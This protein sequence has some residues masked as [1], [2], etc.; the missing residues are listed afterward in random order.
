[1]SPEN[2]C[3]AGAGVSASK[4]KEGKTRRHRH[5]IKIKVAS[6]GSASVG[7]G[8]VLRNLRSSKCSGKH[9]KRSDSS[10]MDNRGG[11]RSSG[12][13]I[14]VNSS[15][16]KAD[17]S[18]PNLE[19]ALGSS[20][21][22]ST[23]VKSVDSLNVNEG[24]DGSFINK[25]LEVNPLDN[26]KVNDVTKSNGLKTSS[27]HISKNESVIASGVQNGGMDNFVKATT[28]NDMDMTGSDPNNEHTS[29]EDVVSTGMPHISD[30]NGIVSDKGGRSFEFG[31]NEKAKG[32]L[33]KPIGPLLTVHFDKNNF[34]NPFVKK[35]L[36]QKGSAWNTS[37][38]NGFGKPILSNQFTADADRFAEKLKQ[39]S[40]EM[41][42][43]MEYSPDAVSKLDNGTKRI[44][45]TAEEV[46]KGGLACA[47]QLYGYFVGTSMDYRV[48]SGNLMKMWRIHGIEE[49]TKT[50]N[51]IFYF[52][53]KSEE[54]MRTVLDSGPWMVQNVPLVLNI[55]EP[56]IW[57][58]KTEPTAIPIWVC[59]YNIPMELC[60]GNGIGK[61]MSGVGKPM[62]MD[63]MTKER[64]LKKAGK[65]DFAR[66]LVEV[67]ASED[68]PNVLEIE[69]PPMGN[70]PAKIGKLDVKYQWKPP[71]CT[72]CK[73]FGHTTLSC[74]I[75]PR[76]KDE[77]V[78]KAKAEEMKDVGVN[79]PK[80]SNIVDE[81]DNDGFVTVG[82]NN[83]PVNSKVKNGSGSQ[84]NNAQNDS[85]NG[86]GN[87]KAGVKQYASYSNGKGVL[88]YQGKGNNQKKFQ[89]KNKNYNE[90]N[91]NSSRGAGVHIKN[92]GPKSMKKEVF[93]KKNVGSTNEPKSLHKL[94]KDPN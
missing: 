70:R 55:W 81:V 24:N 14:D 13:N 48:V 91:M 29:M 92:Q 9:R 69:Y 63:R 46:S 45:F 51:G 8:S 94:S 56:G 22:S 1:M 2:I 87:Y 86:G 35:H 62:V 90:E 67:S 49:I 27:V 18:S 15:N 43:K 38:V 60:N 4:G 12:C 17:V 19:F 61:I 5:G 7:A 11:K 74:K 32:L 78:A 6:P 66:V 33:T 59:V 75:R 82:K 26:K 3:L 72:H 34:N 36:N 16:L 68:L 79:G 25:P 40:E 28:G 65:L 39:G 57:L 47:L 41:A 85:R 89:S 50:S 77:E 52:K 88:N 20:Y 10:P 30:L 21:A 84:F 23:A 64:C 31:K 83:K 37:S 71:L 44:Q 76:T 53:F 80:V 54:G 93:V 58:E 73:T 42:L